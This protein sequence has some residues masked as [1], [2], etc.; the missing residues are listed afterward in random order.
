MWDL[1]ASLLLAGV[2]VSVLASAFFSLT[3][4]ALLSVNRTRLRFLA[5]QGSRR[6]ATALDLLHR[7][8]RLLATILIGNTFAN[9]LASVLTTALALRVFH[10]YALGIATGVLTLLLLI[11]GEIAPKSFASE[12]AAWT[13]LLVARPIRAFAAA[14][15]P[16]EVALSWVAR[17]LLAL[18]GSGRVKPTQFHTEEEIKVLLR[19]GREKGHIGPTE[20]RL[21]RAVFEFNDLRLSDV[22]RSP[23]EIKSVRASTP[24]SRVPLLVAQTGHSRFPVLDEAGTRPLGLVTSR[25]FLVAAPDQL[26]GLTVGSVLRALPQFRPETHLTVALEQMQEEESQMAAI[27]DGEGTLVGLVTIEDI[28]QEI[29]GDI[30]DEYEAA[31]RRVARDRARLASPPP[32]KADAPRAGDSP[33]SRA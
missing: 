25:D 9:I 26:E 15:R 3:E 17:G 31:R 6:A 24:L 12:H 11:V 23:S 7:P 32:P 33:S 27:V 29:V 13:A 14:F 4:T 22:M 21:I 5:D 10:S 16:V 28:L 20:E 1:T 30:H 2:A 18:I 19:V 8:R